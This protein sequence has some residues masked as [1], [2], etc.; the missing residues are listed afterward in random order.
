[1]G[2]IDAEEGEYGRV[3][4]CMAW[5]LSNPGMKDTVVPEVTTRRW[6]CGDHSMDVM[7][8][9]KLRVVVKFLVRRSHHL[10]VDIRYE[11]LRTVDG[12]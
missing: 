6:V 4:L 5:P 8:F 1:M 12:D 9:A 3:R 7:G 10:Y 11:V 2:W